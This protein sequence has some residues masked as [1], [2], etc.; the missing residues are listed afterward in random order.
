MLIIDSL[1]KIYDTDLLKKKHTALDKLS[2]TLQ[3][4]TITGFLGPNGAGKTTSIKIIFDFI[5][6]SSGKVIYGEKLGGNL[7]SALKLMG[8]MPERPYFY[9]DIHGKDFLNYLGKLSGLTSATINE[10]INYWAPRLKIDHALNRKLGNYSKGMLQRI[11]FLAAI[12]HKPKLLVLDEPASGL[13]PLG[14]KELKDVIKEVHA[15]GVSIFFSTHIV[16]DV[17]EICSRLVCIKDGSC[18]YDGPL[19]ELITKN[20][21]EQYTIKY[22]KQDTILI[23]TTGPQDLHSELQTILDEKLSILSVEPKRLSL[24]EIIYKTGTVAS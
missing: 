11:G 16:S 7:T 18:S 13:D 21:L 17:E 10:R 2:F 24:E 8:Y 5:R 9:A 14:R 23:K 4:G 1:T 15:Q 3:E 6:S 20:S 22:L 19:N 12:I